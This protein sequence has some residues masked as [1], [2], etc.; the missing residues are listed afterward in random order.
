MTIKQKLNL[1]AILV[2]IFSL[3]IVGLAIDKALVQRSD[4][5]KVEN[6]NTLSQKLSLLIHE[7]QKERGASAGFIG[8][9]GHKFKDI[10]PKQRLLTDSKYKGLKDY[11]SK[12]DL[13]DFTTELNNAISSFESKFNDIGKIRLKVDS[14]QISVK[15]EVAFYSKINTNILNIV[16]LTAKFSTS[17]EL[18]KALSSYTN[19]LKSKE[20]AGIERAVLSATFGA[21]KFAP[22]IFSKWTKLVAEQDSYLDSFLSLASDNSKLLYK[23]KMNSDVISKVNNMR[24]IATQKEGTG[25]F[26]IDSIVWF[27]TI[28]KKINL[29]KQVDDELAKQN[30]QILKVIE[31]ESTMTAIIT[32]LSYTIFSIMMF[33]IIYFIGKGIN[34]SVNDSLQKIECVSS[35]LDLTC[36]VRVN[37]KD[38]IS[39]ISNAIHVMIIAFKE[40]VHKAVHVSVS[41]SEQ[42]V[43][44][45]DIVLELTKNGDESSN[46]IENIN[47]LVSEVGERLDAVEEASITVTEDLSKTFNVLDNF[48]SE[49]DGVVS[50]I[51]QSNENQ[52][53]L[54]QK[55]SSLTEQAKNIKDVLE[56]ISDIADQTNLLALNAAIEAARAGEHGRGFAVV[57]DEV[58]KLAERTQKSLSEI[59]ANVNL[60]TQNVVEISQETNDT[61]QNM[62]KIAESANELINSAQD[63]KSNLLITKDKSTDVMHQ[64]TYIATKTKE[65]I[66]TMDEIILISN[67]SNQLRENVDSTASTLS[68]DASELQKELKKFTI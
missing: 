48:V 30:N 36:E 2:I 50:S 11:L 47:I 58:R 54:V 29:L 19:F 44:L 46:K 38:E 64:S 6:L 61:S 15:D 31:S 23:N 49:L 60:I 9:N 5:K 26:G 45:G 16:S 33:I 22:G 42:S 62:H 8:S 63:T 53:E 35:D 40:S 27:N 68:N 55:V 13:S 12:L 67:K 14:L 4:I 52:Q 28:T 66:S 37:G 51:G 39:Q 10:I 18:V 17:P 25:G 65:L 56:I 34:Y 20:R 41:T 24:K 59:S 21:D 43:K 57:A 7:T 32:I 3:V 1:I